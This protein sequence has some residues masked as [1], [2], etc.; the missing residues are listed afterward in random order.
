MKEVV[1]EIIGLGEKIVDQNIKGGN[2]EVLGLVVPST[3]E[4]VGVLGVVVSA[5]K[6]A[7]AL[8]DHLFSKR[9]EDFTSELTS[10]TTEQKIRFYEKYSKKNIQDFGEQAILLLNK[11]EMPL[12]AKLIGRAHYLLVSGEIDES[13]YFNYCHVSKNINRYI[14]EN[15]LSTY[16][17]SDQQIFKGGV[18][19]LLESLGLMFEIREGLYP[20][21]AADENNPQI[22]ITRYMKSDFGKDFYQQIVGPYI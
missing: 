15:L 20:S 21:K 1:N 6:G 9:F 2:L 12:A 16:T 10:L 19:S 3:L 5:V 18:F 7:I 17:N 14:Y 13:T 11:I 22:K 8:N 4:E